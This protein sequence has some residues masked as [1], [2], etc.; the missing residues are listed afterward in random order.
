MCLRLKG[1]KVCKN[2]KLTFVS[3]RNPFYQNVQ[4]CATIS[5]DCCCD[6]CSNMLKSLVLM[7]HLIEQQQL[8]WDGKFHLSGATYNRVMTKIGYIF[9][10]SCR[11]V[12]NTKPPKV[13]SLFPL[14]RFSGLN[15]VLNRFFITHQF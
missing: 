9:C 3:T 10:F 12:E 1:L 5:C 4:H 15:R 13:R 6:C 8:S 14:S 2:V 7:R 11:A